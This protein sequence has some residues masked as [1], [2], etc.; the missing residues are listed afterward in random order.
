MKRVKRDVPQFVL[1]DN[2]RIILEATGYPV[3]SFTE[4]NSRIHAGG[5]SLEEGI[6]YIMDRVNL[7]LIDQQRVTAGDE[8]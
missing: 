6:E 8:T 5:M 3:T 2:N 7:A 1:L 4:C